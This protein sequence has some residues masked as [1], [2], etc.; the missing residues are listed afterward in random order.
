MS[1]KSVTSRPAKGIIGFIRWFINFLKRTVEQFLMEYNFETREWGKGPHV[2]KLD[3]TYKFEIEK[4]PISG[5][6]FPIVTITEKRWEKRKE[7]R[8]PTSTFALDIV[9]DHKNGWWQEVERCLSDTRSYYIYV[10]K[11]YKGFIKVDE[12]NSR[13]IPCLTYEEAMQAISLYKERF[14]HFNVSTNHVETLK[15][16]EKNSQRIIVDKLA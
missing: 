5:Y 11:N 9:I 4:Q 15:V 6:Y 16:T 3:A 1:M 7:W 12:S 10:E 14:L 8:Q 13:D 2:H